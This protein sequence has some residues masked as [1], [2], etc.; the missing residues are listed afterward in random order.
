MK[1]QSIASYYPYNKNQNCNNQSSD[2]KT[3]LMSAKVSI[4]FTGISEDKKQNNNL[5]MRFLSTLA[6]AGLFNVRDGEKKEDSKILF[7]AYKSNPQLTKELARI[8]Y[9]SCLPVFDA[10][11]I[12]GLVRINE[13]DP[14]FVS[15]LT[16]HDSAGII[17]N[18]LMELHKILPEVANRLACSEFDDTEI[19]ELAKL[20]KK[21]FET[22][23]Q[24]GKPMG[25]QA[26][27]TESFIKDF[28]C[29]DKHFTSDDIKLIPMCI[30][31]V[32]EKYSSSEY[33]RFKSYS[34]LEQKKHVFNKLNNLSIIDKNILLFI[35]MANG[36]FSDS[37]VEDLDEIKKFLANSDE[38]DLQRNKTNL[39]NF[40]KREVNEE[41]I[42]NEVS[43]N[44]LY[45]L[46]DVDKTAKEIQEVNWEECSEEELINK[47][48]IPIEKINKYFYE[49]KPES[50]NDIWG[51]AAEALYQHLINCEHL[52]DEIKN[53]FDLDKSAI[54]YF[55]TDKGI[56]RY[57]F[58]PTLKNTNYPLWTAKIRRNLELKNAEQHN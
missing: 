25:K 8:K 3:I 58:S 17:C 18:T 31:Y 27:K 56:F 53:I 20:Y 22:A 11:E 15:N 41:K 45:E 32:P 54:A 29:Y 39:A 40:L 55:D 30:K 51:Y 23:Q 34:Y 19:E 52:P 5:K 46:K 24:T 14:T 7:E 2:K 42:R 26:E 6:D 4:N 33:L 21:E 28:L 47:V 10:K 44:P 48:I 13:K 38:K 37:E 9:P 57:N 43:R 36:C 12:S 49:T 1:I 16:E 50:A 35:I